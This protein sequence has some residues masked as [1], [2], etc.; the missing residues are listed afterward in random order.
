MK[1][2]FVDFD[3]VVIDS[4]PWHLK[5]YQALIERMGKELTAS[6]FSNL[7]MGRSEREIVSAMELNYDIQIDY[8]SFSRQRDEIIKT[9]IKAKSIPI[10]GNVQ[11]YLRQFSSTPRFILS[12]QSKEIIE[13]TLEVYRIGGFEGIFSAPELG[14]GKQ[15]IAMDRVQFG[16]LIID[17]NIKFLL[18]CRDLTDR[19]LYVRHSMN[20]D[21]DESIETLH[22]RGVGS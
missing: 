1:S 15:R 16:D 4:E 22:G 9:Y 10:M 5:S 7:Y 14:K 3:G 19:L 6:Q 11:A 2:I 13:L 18:S 20:S 8:D 21:V 12:S 17:D